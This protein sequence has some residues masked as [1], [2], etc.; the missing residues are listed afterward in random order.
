MAP[1]PFKFSG[2]GSILPVHTSTH[3]RLHRLSEPHKGEA[4]EGTVCCASAQSSVILAAIHFNKEA[5]TISLMSSSL[6][7]KRDTFGLVVS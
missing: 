6:T 1:A 2:E 7:A 5:A 4:V 3:A